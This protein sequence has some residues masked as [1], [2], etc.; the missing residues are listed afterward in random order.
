MTDKEYNNSY[1][2][3]YDLFCSQYRAETNEEERNL[4][5]KR[6]ADSF[7]KSRDIMPE[8]K[9]DAMRDFLFNVRE[10]NRFTL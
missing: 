4:Y 2:G 7:F 9:V 3:W 8:A 5:K 10:I 6:L 1:C